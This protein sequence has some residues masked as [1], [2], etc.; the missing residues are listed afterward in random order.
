MK[1]NVNTTKKGVFYDETDTYHSHFFFDFNTICMVAAFWGETFTF[2]ESQL[3]ADTAPV[4]TAS[5]PDTD[6]KKSSTGRKKN[7]SGT[8]S[9][10]S[11]NHLSEEK[12]YLK[13]PGEY[14]SVYFS[15]TDRLYL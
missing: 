1:R 4:Q 2:G 12:Y 13:S 6:S 8:D 11:M 9:V 15:D 10:E 5:C 14:L 7:I 3:K